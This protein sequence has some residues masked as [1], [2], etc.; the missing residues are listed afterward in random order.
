MG[1]SQFGICF[2]K[3]A[4]FAKESSYISQRRIDLWAVVF[5]VWLRFISSELMKKGLDIIDLKLSDTEK[6]LY[7]KDN[8]TDFY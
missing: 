1:I 2:V 4:V 8:V 3:N 5:V 7:F 6:Y